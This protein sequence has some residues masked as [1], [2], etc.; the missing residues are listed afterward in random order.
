[1]LFLFFLPLLQEAG[2]AI[3]DG[4]WRQGIACS[5]LSHL[6]VNNQCSSLDAGALITVMP[7]REIFTFFSRHSILDSLLLMKGSN[8]LVKLA[9]FHPTLIPW[10]AVIDPPGSATAAVTQNPEPPNAALQNRK[11]ASIFPIPFITILN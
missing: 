10:D 3:P 1:L 5:F 4:P 7:R 2:G 6:T 9:F 8:R 11:P